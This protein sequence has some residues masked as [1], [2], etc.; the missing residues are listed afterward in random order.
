[1]TVTN[2]INASLEIW[3]CTLSVIVFL[4]LKLSRRHFDYCDRL[5]FWILGCNFGVLLFDVLALFFRGH[6]GNFFWWGVRFANFAAFCLNYCLLESFTHYLTVFMNKRTTVSFL[7]LYITR[8]ICL[9]S[10]ILTV[11]TQFTP[12][13]YTIDADNMYHRADLFFLS[14]LA[15]II[16]MFINAGILIRHRK[17][18]DAQEKIVLWS[19]IVLP[20]LAMLIQ[21]HFY[22]L[23]LL[24]LSDTI[25]ITLI[26]LFLQAE[27]GRIA[28]EHEQQM[29]QD[30]VSIMLS[31]I[32]P[33]FLYNA[34]C[35]IQ[36]M[37]HGKAPDAEESSIEFAEFLR[38]NMDSLQ[39]RSPITFEQELK[40]TKNYLSLEQKRFGEC[41]HVIYDIHATNFRIP[42]LTLQPVVENAVKYG[43]MKKDE[44]GTVIIR[45]DET[46]SSFII[47]VI[48]D[49]I[50]FDP[51]TT[52]DDGRTHIGIS[53]VQERLK[54]MCN[55]TLDISSISGKGTTAVITVP[56][57]Y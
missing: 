10:V 13:I 44:G 26:F 35:V 56:K 22:G 24:N 27:Q 43:I 2:Y 23:A 18:L 38:G 21:I 41:L 31:Q 52:K 8:I 49:G 36:E 28:A 40:H 47:S 42:A 45:T 54:V 29:L 1:M 34:L 17:V 15:G 39:S 30:R 50:G 20:V 19:Y 25:S 32:Q 46:S 16:G 51:M 53:N 5:Y 4:C 33:H 14:Q 37:C 7:P 11:I 57:L 9:I 48:D 12:I 6:P 3:G 55:A